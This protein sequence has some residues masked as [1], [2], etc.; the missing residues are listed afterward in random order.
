MKRSPLHRQAASA[1]A[2]GRHDDALRFALLG[3]RVQAQ[4]ALV[5]ARQRAAARDAR[6]AQTQLKLIAE[7]EALRQSA[8]G[9]EEA[10]RIARTAFAAGALD[11]LKFSAARGRPKGSGYNDGDLWVEL[12]G[13]CYIEGDEPWS[14]VAWE[15][16]E[17][18]PGGGTRASRAERLE[19]KAREWLAE[20][21]K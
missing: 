2:E 17:H 12:I 1:R 18:A 13:R 15:L 6:A 4:G 3:L 19:R 11:G 8:A 5:A 20:W 14:G 16:A 7:I 10:E 21:E 9:P